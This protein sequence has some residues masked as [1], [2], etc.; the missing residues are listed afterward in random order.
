[1]DTEFRVTNTISYDQNNQ[2]LL[3]FSFVGG[4]P[5]QPGYAEKSTHEE[6]NKVVGD[7]IQKTIDLVRESVQKGSL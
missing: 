4:V 2:L 3:T 7:V 1:M 6:L 5:G